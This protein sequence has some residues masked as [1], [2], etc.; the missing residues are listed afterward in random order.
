MYVDYETQR[1]TP[2][3]SADWYAEVIRRN[4]LRGR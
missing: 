2:K 1:L 4:R 3:S